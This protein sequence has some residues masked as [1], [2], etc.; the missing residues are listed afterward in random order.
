MRDIAKENGVDT[1]SGSQAQSG[2][3]KRYDFQATEQKLGGGVEM[4]R[5]MDNWVMPMF[6][7]YMNRTE[8][9]YD[10]K[11]NYPASFYPEEEPTMDNMLEAIGKFSEYG[12]MEARNAVALRMVKKLLGRDIEKSDL[13]E[14]E[15]AIENNTVNNSLAE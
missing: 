14:I 2:D 12:M 1:K 15:Q 8:G 9:A 7:K 10:Y 13:D 4:A 6:D 5:T 11:R 3:S